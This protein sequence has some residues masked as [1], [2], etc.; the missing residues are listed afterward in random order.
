MPHWEVAWDHATMVLWDFALNWDYEGARKLGDKSRAIPDFSPIR[1]PGG[2]TSQ[3][4]VAPAD[5]P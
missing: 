4:E 2:D 5:P 3:E 1:P